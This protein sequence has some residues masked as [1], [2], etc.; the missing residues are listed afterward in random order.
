MLEFKQSPVS[1][2]LS[3]LEAGCFR[4]LESSLHFLD[5]SSNRLST[6]DPAALG[7]LGALANLTHNPWHCDCNMQ[8]SFICTGD[9]REDFLKSKSNNKKYLFITLCNQ[10][11]SWFY[12]EI[13]FIFVFSCHCLCWIWTQSLWL[14]SSVKALT[15]QT[16]VCLL[17]GV[18]SYG[19][20]NTPEH[21]SQLIKV[22]N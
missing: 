13:I 16:S 14:K 17:Q 12:T 19:P 22:F 4:G 5:L 18:L 9:I 20:R 6:L 8:V 11:N 10:N 2:Q 21:T 1:L 15:S 3:F 7:D